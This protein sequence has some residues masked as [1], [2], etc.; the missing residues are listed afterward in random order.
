MHE[1]KF[2]QDQYSAAKAKLVHDWAP[3]VEV[4]GAY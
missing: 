3:A 4:E 2:L 1:Q